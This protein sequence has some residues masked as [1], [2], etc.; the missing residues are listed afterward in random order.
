MELLDSGNF[1]RNS[2]V[3]LS[4]NVISK[5]IEF[6]TVSSDLGISFTDVA[7]TGVIATSEKKI[8]SCC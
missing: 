2:S 8:Q 3:E 6:G 4:E 1:S 7:K 5:L